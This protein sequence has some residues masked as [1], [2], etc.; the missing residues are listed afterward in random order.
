MFSKPDEQSTAAA[1][2]PVRTS[3]R[4]S[5]IAPSLRIIGNVE[6]SGN[7]QLDGILDGDIQGAEL[8]VGEGA[9][10][11][12]TVTAEK[13]KIAGE[14]NGLI[15]G[16][17]VELCAS[18]KVAGDIH[19][20]SLSVEA[21]AFLEGLCQRSRFDPDFVKKAPAGKNLNVVADAQSGAEAGKSK[22]VGTS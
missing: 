16:R 20:D 8:T 15:T 21:G 9:V 12:G 3:E 11:N 7:V 6:C 2:L 10:I 13:V 17:V 18:A 14:V 19:H 4:P 1:E 22:D 5:L